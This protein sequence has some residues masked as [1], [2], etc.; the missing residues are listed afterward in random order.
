MTL[1]LV[2][3]VLLQGLTIQIPIGSTNAPCVSACMVQDSDPVDSESLQQ[4]EVIRQE[5][6]LLDAGLRIDG[7]SDNAATHYRE[8][9]RELIQRRHVYDKLVNAVAD[10][11][12]S[13][14][15]RDCLLAPAIVVE[16]DMANSIGKSQASHDGNKNDKQKVGRPELGT[17][18]AIGTAALLGIVVGRLSK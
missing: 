1:P 15:D 14:P 4:Q 13:T 10:R 2:A 17:L 11:F 8:L 12:L 7:K 18:L 9:F 5:L 3:S 16:V 6:E